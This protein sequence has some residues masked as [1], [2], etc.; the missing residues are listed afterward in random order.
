MSNSNNIINYDTDESDE[1]ITKEIIVKDVSTRDKRLNVFIK[2]V[3]LSHFNT[4]N[5]EFNNIHF[6]NIFQKYFIFIFFL[7]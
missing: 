6:F 5:N 1:H 3:E 4:I 7:L 2:Y